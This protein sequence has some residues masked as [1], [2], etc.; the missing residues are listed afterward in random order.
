M[1]DG[2]HD[3]IITETLSA[4]GLLNGICIGTFQEDFSLC[5]AD[6]LRLLNEGTKLTSWSL[7]ILFIAIGYGMSIAA[8][9]LS[10]FIEKTD[11]VSDA[12]IVILAVSFLT[13]LVLY[14]VG[15]L[16]PNERKNLI[17]KISNHFKTA[18]KSRRFFQEGK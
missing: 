7:N 10:D 8:K 11:S 4:P 15:K 16:L 12:E 5:E 17:S 3:R 18:P 2:V 9:L 13:S 1:H 6:F 14:F